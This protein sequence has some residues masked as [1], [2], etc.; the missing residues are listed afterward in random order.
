MSFAASWTLTSV[1]L[2]IH[3]GRRRMGPAMTEMVPI[4]TN[5]GRTSV[6]EGRTVDPSTRVRSPSATPVSDRGVHHPPH[7]VR[8]LVGL[9]PRQQR[10][11]LKSGRLLR[12]KP[13][14]GR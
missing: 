14:L 8:L 4:S 6:A 7:A 10:T 9:L 12:R 11:R 5:G 13:I 3:A 2:D 1:L